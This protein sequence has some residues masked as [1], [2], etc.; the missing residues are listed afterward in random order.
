MKSI[1]LRAALIAANNVNLNGADALVETAI[2]KQLIESCK[3]RIEEL[4]DE[5]KTLAEAKLSALGAKKGKFEHNGHHFTLD[6]ENVYDLIGN[7][8]KYNTTDAATYRR[9]AREQRALKE[10]SSVL[11]KEMKAIYDA[12]P[13][14]H[15]KMEPDEVKRT[16]KCI[17]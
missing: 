8:S 17:D 15:P 1:D 12:Y 11:T 2:L 4:E 16:L 5:A 3:A 6:R 13:I 9:K 7:T 14:N 10:Q